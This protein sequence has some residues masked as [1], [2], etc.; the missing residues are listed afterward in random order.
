MHTVNM[1]TVTMHTVTMHTVTMHM[2]TTV[3]HI[4]MVAQVLGSMV[5]FKSISQSDRDA[6]GESLIERVYEAEQAVVT[7]GEPSDALPQRG[8]S[9]SHSQRNPLPHPHN[10]PSPSLTPSNPRV[11]TVACRKSPLGN[12]MM[13][14]PPWST[15]L[16]KTLS[17]GLVRVGVR[18][19]VRV[20]L[21]CF[22]RYVSKD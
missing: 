8:L 17:L 10:A 5:I 7:Q 15:K 11:R 20:R 13:P 2:H 9:A 6:L 16:M 3:M 22:N 14:V 1:H 12:S 18:V 4:C 21:Y 19:G